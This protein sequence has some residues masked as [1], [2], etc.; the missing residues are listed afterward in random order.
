MVVEWVSR[1]SPAALKF[2]K[3]KCRGSPLRLHKSPEEVCQPDFWKTG[4]KK[5]VTNIY[6]KN[7]SS[8]LKLKSA[9]RGV[10]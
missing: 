8:F 9:D 10:R 6:T 7:I 3:F 2:K 1:T 5:P 4:R